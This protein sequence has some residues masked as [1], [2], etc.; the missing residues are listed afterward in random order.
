MVS[1]Q[2]KEIYNSEMVGARLRAL[3]EERRVSLDALVAG[4]KIQKKYLEALEANRF[5]SLG[6]P[7]YTQNFIKAYARYLGVPHQPLVDNFKDYRDE[8][9]AAN[10][11][12]VDVAAPKHRFAVSYKLIRN[13][14]FAIVALALLGYIGFA[15]RNILTP[16][17]ITVSFPPNDY[18]A[19]SQ[20]IE[21]AGKVAA[22]TTL[23]INGEEALTDEA[24]NFKEK[25]DLGEGL[26]TIKLGAQ[27]KHS[28]EKVIYW[29]IFYGTAEKVSQ[30]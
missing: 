5:D 11:V 26:N 28:A 9:D 24:G 23:K 12:F 16:P 17:P 20:Q 4:T 2:V 6:S 22:D 15:V 19:E 13:L 8:S 7:I 30:R 10:R 29:R 1:F 3:R 21:I 25:V 27:R 18:V 14:G